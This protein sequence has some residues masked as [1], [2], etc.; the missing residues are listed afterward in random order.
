[1]WRYNSDSASWFFITLSQKIADT[2]KKETKPSNGW[3]QRKVEVT[4]G[5]TTWSTSIF[6]NKHKTFDVPIKASV[7]KAEGLHEGDKIKAHIR[8]T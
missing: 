2:I 5:K 7:R 8:I 4:I 1:M 6:P 3:G